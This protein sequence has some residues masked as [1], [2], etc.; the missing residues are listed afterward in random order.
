MRNIWATPS[1]LVHWL[2]TTDSI[3]SVNPHQEHIKVFRASFQQIATR[4]CQWETESDLGKSTKVLILKNWSQRSLIWNQIWDLWGLQRKGLISKSGLFMLGLRSV[5]FNLEALLL[6]DWWS[7]AGWR[8]DER[9]CCMNRVD[10][11]MGSGC[12]SKMGN[13]SVNKV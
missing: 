8:G 2:F 13:F 10:D 12:K 4:M 9:L 1:I 7:V 6:M 5:L 3:T 11:V